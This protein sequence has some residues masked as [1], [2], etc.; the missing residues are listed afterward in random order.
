MLCYILVR[1][2]CIAINQ[3]PSANST[4]SWTGIDKHTL[5]S[6]LGYR[7]GFNHIIEKGTLTLTKTDEFLERVVSDQKKIVVDFCGNFITNFRE[8]TM[9][10]WKRGG[11]KTVRSFFSSEN[12]SV[13]VSASHFS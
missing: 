12:S 2:G 3:T 1:P 9:N 11:L 7:D 10:F 6:S 13:L 4:E 8:K 5:R